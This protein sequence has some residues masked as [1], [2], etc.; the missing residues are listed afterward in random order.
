MVLEYGAGGPNIHPRLWQ[1][2]P[3]RILARL[4]GA[5][6]LGAPD[7]VGC[8]H[9]MRTAKASSGMQTL[10]LLLAASGSYPTSDLGWTRG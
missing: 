5:A 8:C 1:W 9:L 2:P 6:S 4:A 10:R 3:E 7:E